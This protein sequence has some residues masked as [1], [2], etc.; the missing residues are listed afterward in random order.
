LLRESLYALRDHDSGLEAPE[1]KKRDP[2]TEL[3]DE[4][5]VEE[6]RRALQESVLRPRSPEGEGASEAGLTAIG[7]Q[8]NISEC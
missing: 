2:R 7:G 4:E 8:D 5:R 1:P 3:S 6:T